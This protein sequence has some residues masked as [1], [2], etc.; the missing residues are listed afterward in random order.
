[1]DCIVCG[2]L[3]GGKV[4]G[5]D[6]AEMGHWGV[7]KGERGECL[8]G[9]EATERDIDQRRYFPCP[10]RFAI[11]P[12]SVWYCRRSQGR[13]PSVPVSKCKKDV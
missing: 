10:L 2:V 4:G 11:R 1:M 8:A 3:A 9:V 12:V 6:G 7:G 13:V 5:G